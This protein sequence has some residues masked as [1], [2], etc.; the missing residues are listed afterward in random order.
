LAA[1]LADA[2]NK[3]SQTQES[4]LTLPYETCTASGCTSQNGGVTMDSNWRWTHKTGET[5]NCYTGNEWDQSLCPDSAQC[6]E[7][8][9][10]DGIDDATWTGTYGVNIQGSDMTLSFVTQGPYSRNVGSRTYLLDE[11]HQKYVKFMLLNQEFSFDVD[12]SNLPCGLNGALY[13]VEMDADGGM[14]Y[15]TNDCGAEFGTGYCDAQCPHDMKWINGE[16]NCDDWNPSDNDQNAGTGHYGSCCAEMDLWEANSMAQ[17]YT[18][19]PCEIDG[20]Y[21]CE[22]TECGDNAADERYDGVCDKDGCDWAAF[23][24]GDEKFYGPGSDYVIDTT[25]PVTVVTQFFTD[26]DTPN[27]NLKNIRRKYVQNGKVIENTHIMWDGINI[28]PYDEINDGFCKDVKEVYGDNNHHDEIGGLKKMGDQMKNGM[29][30]AMSLWDDHEANM[31]WLDSNYPVGCDPTDPTDHGCHRGPC[32]E[33]SG[34]PD[35]VE[36]QYPDASVTYGKLR[37]GDI[38]TTYLDRLY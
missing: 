33:D 18:T 19:H 11:S 35:D 24:L 38:D 8:C 17:A 9:A 22:G 34:V 30:L 20:A 23:R 36:E 10:L 7:N 5:T 13:L 12:V 1:H 14:S 26:D 27:G 15:P 31:L 16:A 37:V 32:P 6:T 29:V 25:K 28:E 21:R 4:T 3:G 2:Q